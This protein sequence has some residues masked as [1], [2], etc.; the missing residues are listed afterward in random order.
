MKHCCAVGPGWPNGLKIRRMICACCARCGWLRRNGTPTMS[1]TPSAG[2]MNACS[3]CMTVP[4]K[5]LGLEPETDLTAA[6]R[7]FTR[8]EFDRL[9]AELEN[10]TTDHRRRSSIGER[11]EDLGDGGYGTGRH[12]VGLRMDGMPDIEWCEIPNNSNRPEEFIDFHVFNVSTFWIAKYPITFVQFQAFIDDPEG[13]TNPRWWERLDIEKRHKGQAASQRFKLDNQPREHVSWY[14]AIAFCRWLTAKLPSNA[15]PSSVTKVNQQWQ[16]RIPTEWEWLRAASGGNPVNRYPWGDRWNN[17]IVNTHE[18]EL[19]R[20]IAVGMYPQN[21]S[22]FKA[23]DMLGNTWEWCINE[24]HE[25][26][27]VE[28]TG[29]ND[30]SMRGGAFNYRLI[31]SILRNNASPDTRATEIGFRVMCGIPIPS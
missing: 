10:P 9:L 18:A 23:L 14:D 30:R 29:S 26:E 16:L 25:L 28:L 19:S 21:S 8:R 6:E 24:Y 5:T 31:H 3:R 4:L 11:L 13:F 17:K 12:G 2:R 1:R 20:P 27:K 15:W 22:P 7:E